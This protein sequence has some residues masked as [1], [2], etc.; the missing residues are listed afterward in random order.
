MKW[1]YKL[2]VLRSPIS[3]HD[4]VIVQDLAALGELGWEIVA[5]WPQES[6]FAGTPLHETVLLCK[7]PLPTGDTDAND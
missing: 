2:A 7:R 3:A 5:A 4:K 6:K 1:E